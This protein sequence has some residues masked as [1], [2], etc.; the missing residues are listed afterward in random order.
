MTKKRIDLKTLQDTPPWEWPEDADKSL[1]GILRDTQADGDERLLAAELSGDY[2][3][4][5]DE[6]AGELLSI[7][8][9][10]HES[11]A[12]RGEALLSLGTALEHADMMGFDDEDVILISEPVFHK[13]QETL[14]KLY[15][16]TDTPQTLRRKVLETS[17]QA[18]QPWHTT[19][20][21]SAYASEDEI[22]RTTAVFAMRFVRGFDAQ[23]IESLSSPNPEIQYH[24][25]CA[26]GNWQLDEAWPTVT[27]LVA[28]D[29]TDKEMLLAAIEAVGNIRPDQALAV[30]GPLMDSDDEDIAEAVYETLT[31]AEDPQEDEEDG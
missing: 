9:N 20:V 11:E 29:Q 19:A 24:A 2:V 1:L 22:W 23:I 30:L 28:S 14:R 18:P 26:A 7:G 15:M 8:R 3:V 31:M 21:R 17:V 12:L 16:D 5:N 25:V 6:L 4:I 10:R 13:I 27:A